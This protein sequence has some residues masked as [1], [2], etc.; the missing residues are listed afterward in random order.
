VRLPALSG[1]C[2][3]ANAAMTCM[4]V[5]LRLFRRRPCLLVAFWYPGSV[6]VRYMRSALAPPR[7]H[8]PSRSAMA[9]AGKQ[10]RSVKVRV[11]QLQVCWWP[12][13][14]VSVRHISSAIAPPQPQSVSNGL[15]REVT[16]Y[17]LDSAVI[18]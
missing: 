18:R 3:S 2:F 15:H 16:I 11:L 6:S 9:C 7:L 5:P 17:A 10:P 4:G 12:S 8:L 1:S 14:I 13:D